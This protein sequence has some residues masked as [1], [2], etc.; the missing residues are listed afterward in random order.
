MAKE[1]KPEK[2]K[3][4]KGKPEKGK[5][6]KDKPGKG[7]PGKGKPEKG[8]PGKGKGKGKGKLEKAKENGKG[9]KTKK[10][11]NK[12]PNKNKKSIKDSPRSYDLKKVTAPVFMINGASDDIVTN[13][14]VKIL[15]N[16]VGSKQKEF[17]SVKGVKYGHIDHI[18]NKYA[19]KLVYEKIIEKMDG[20]LN[21]K[22]N[23]NKKPGKNKQEKKTE[24]NKTGKNGMEK[25]K[26]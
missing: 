6:G 15:F 8:K 11:D 3:P 2:G 10:K 17:I 19:R 7:K 1:E 18:W 5:P 4:G 24:K 22:K 16:K 13:E 23:K 12:K 20:F 26:A 14:D 9:K 25:T 21:K